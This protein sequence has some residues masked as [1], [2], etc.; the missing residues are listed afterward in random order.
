MERN[1]MWACFISFLLLLNMANCVEEEVKTTLI[2]FLE[3]LSSSNGQQNNTT[4]WTQDTDPCKDSW[5][6]VVCDPSK[7]HVRSLLLDRHNFSGTLDAAMLCKL[8]PLSDYLTVLSVDGNNISGGIAFEVG[9]CTHLTHLIVSG[10]QL[11]GGLPS[12][13]AMLNNLKRLDIS[14]NNFSGELP[15]LSRISGL[16]VFFAQNNHLSGQIPRFD[17]SN[18][19]RFNVSF[20]NFSGPI[21]YV[22]G[23]FFA[24]SFIGNPE[25][26]G[27]PLPK[28]CSSLALDEKTEETEES[29]DGPSKDQILM[30]SG[31]AALGLIV[32]LFVIF[33]LCKRKK[34]EK[35][36]DSVCDLEATH[37]VTDK[38]SIVSSEYK[39]GL[40]KSELS[41]TSESGLASQSLIV[42]ARP[43]ADDLKF[44]D[45]LRAPAE[46]LGRGKN[47]SL[48]K[49]VLDNGMVVVVKRL[50][51][52]TSSSHEFKQ[53]MERL[54]Q[55]K[56][57]IVLPHLAFYTSKQE[58]LLVYEYQ[59][60]G[61]LFK[62]LHGTPKSKAF[63]WTKRLG[64]AAAV[65]DALAYMHQELGE[66]GIAHGNLKSSNILLNINMEPCISEYGITAIDDQNSSS[67]AGSVDAGAP[68][69]FKT[70]VYAFGVILLE[71]LTGKLVKSDGVD[72]TDWVQ[73]VVREEWTG[74]VFDRFL[75]S[76][77]ASEE[78]MVNLLQVAI[79]CINRSA[80]AR[81]S[82]NQ[83]SLVIN[84]IKEEEE[85]SLIYE[86]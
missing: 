46:L 81:P 61:S 33:K 66:D 41:G 25:L 8:Q 29:K 83:V 62:L 47:G 13:L 16:N 44:E 43:V 7:E 60:N 51:D 11:S 6:G 68:D 77:Y 78:R 71:L 21:P 38:S 1:P 22:G 56:H 3:K 45:L 73:S 34:T 75:I 2:S 28:N 50:K 59:H 48:Y 31:Y 65:A 42:V 18:L 85:K 72:L 52:W 54:N 67:F 24:D 37:N 9:N 76:E 57:S 49:V 12:S 5:E 17:F 86:A 4:F 39:G 40:S 23:H 74:E 79:K 64:L 80:E 63:D 14:N 55:V 30:Y 58:K 35:K 19:A 53:R 15:N 20:N 27:N 70:D 10:N 32:V 36:V 26:C 69:A 82:M 84:S